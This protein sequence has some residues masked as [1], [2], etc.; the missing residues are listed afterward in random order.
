MPPFVARFG[1]I[2]EYNEEFIIFCSQFPGIVGNQKNHCQEVIR[3]MLGQC[4]QPQEQ[5]KVSGV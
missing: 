2:R 1:V 3:Q 4:M 5:Q